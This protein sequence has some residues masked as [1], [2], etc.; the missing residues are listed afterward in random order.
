MRVIADHVRA[1][2]RLRMDNCHRIIRLGINPPNLRRAV[3]YGY[4]TLDF[5]RAIY[6]GIIRVLAEEMGAA[7]PELIQQ[8]RIDWQGN[9]EEEISFFR[10][11]A[12]GIAN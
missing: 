2:F 11:L 8:E 9:K 1:I 12:I 10:T 4:Q 3:R 7:F 5:K 6:L